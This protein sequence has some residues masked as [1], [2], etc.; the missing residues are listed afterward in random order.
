MY[1]IL[2]HKDLYVIFFKRQF[3]AFLSWNSVGLHFF[4]IA[5]YLLL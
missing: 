2:N 4:E 1:N 5:S 3:H